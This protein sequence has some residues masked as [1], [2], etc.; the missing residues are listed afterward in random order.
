MNKYENKILVNKRHAEAFQKRKQVVNKCIIRYSTP[1]VTEQ[2]KLKPWV[3]CTNTVRFHASPCFPL[4][5][6]LN[7]RVSWTRAHFKPSLYKLLLISPLL[8]P[9]CS[10]LLCA[11]LFSYEHKLV[12]TTA[13]SWAVLGQPTPW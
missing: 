12:L 5:L 8:A 3:D 4:P 10:V 7:L 9:L 1:I 13:E 6:T 11:P 2:T